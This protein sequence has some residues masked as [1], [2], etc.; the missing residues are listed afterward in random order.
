[1]TFHCEPRD[2]PDAGGGL[3]CIGATVYGPERCTC[4]VPV[5]DLEQAEPVVGPAGFRDEMCADCAYRPR[6]PERRGDPDHL[7][8]EEG[9][10]ALAAAGEPFFCHQGIRRAVRWEHRPEEA[11]AVQCAEV[12]EAAGDLRVGSVPG[13]PQQYL[14]PIIEGVPYR[15]D[16]TPA[17]LCAGWARRATTETVDP[18]VL[19]ALRGLGA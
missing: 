14:P 10:M 4:W 8:T 11:T 18:R 2:Y 17:Q 13:K 7:G 3:C 9:L 6:S 1:M 15:A 16:G 5:Y 19:A 12:L